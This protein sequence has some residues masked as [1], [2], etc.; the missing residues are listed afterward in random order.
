MLRSVASKMPNCVLRRCASAS[1]TTRDYGS[2]SALRRS[3]MSTDAT[4]TP[5]DATTKGQDYGREALHELLDAV[6]KVLCSHLWHLDAVAGTGKR[7]ANRCSRKAA[8]R[9]RRAR[10]GTRCLLTCFRAIVDHEYLVGGRRARRPPPSIA[11][12]NAGGETSKLVS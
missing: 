9:I 3:H 11:N 4:R 8:Q 6:A 1:P 2:I 10:R 7:F 5:D 12:R